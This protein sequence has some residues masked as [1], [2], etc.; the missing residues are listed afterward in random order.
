MS[1]MRIP[2]SV[3]A[4]CLLSGCSVLDN[5]NLGEQTLDPN[6]IYLGRD[7]VRPGPRDDRSRYA[8]MGGALLCELAGTSWEC[9][10]P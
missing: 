3:A 9:R 7:V 4:L 10:C 5:I 8:C 6:R 1:A 2:I